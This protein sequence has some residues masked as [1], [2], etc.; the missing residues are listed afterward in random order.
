MNLSLQL[1]K[2]RVKQ[3]LRQVI[4]LQT[5]NEFEIYDE[6]AKTEFVTVATDIQSWAVAPDGRFLPHRM[7]DGKLT[8]LRD[9]E[10]LTLDQYDQLNQQHE[11]EVVADYQAD[12]STDQIEEVYRNEVTEMYNPE[13]ARENLVKLVALCRR[14]PDKS[15]NV[16]GGNENS[17]FYEIKQEMEAAGEWADNLTILAGEED[18]CDGAD[19]YLEEYRFNRTMPISSSESAAR[20]T[21]L[22]SLLANQGVPL[23]ERQQ[24]IRGYCQPIEFE[25][26]AGSAREALSLDPSLFT[27]ELSNQAQ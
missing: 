7:V 1:G 15:F 18:K 22:D 27:P 2:A 13:F 6:E 12:R 19:I 26:S 16:S 21:A 9:D 20:V 24:R 11:Q 14:F 17:F 3:V 5:T 8:P 25:T 4:P 10:F 23:E